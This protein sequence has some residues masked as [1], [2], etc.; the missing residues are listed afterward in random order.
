MKF[1]V[2]T[3]GGDCPGLNA[4]IRGVVYRAHQGGHS[5]IGFLDGWK[6]VRDALYRPLSVPELAESVGTGGT[7]LGS[8]RTNPF[9]QE[10]DSRHVLQTL[11]ATGVDA[12]VA[13][14]GDDTLSA[15]LQLSRLG[16][17]VVGV[18]KT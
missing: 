4:A 7:L 3:G 10:A 12:L 15:A 11:A 2:L 16:G 9:A 5:A 6:G 13:I 8:S 14:G 18:P 1:G 17:K